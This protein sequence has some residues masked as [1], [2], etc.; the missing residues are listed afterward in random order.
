MY[1]GSK[2]MVL[3]FFK[4]SHAQQCVQHWVLLGVMWQGN[5][6]KVLPMYLNNY[7]FQSQD[8]VLGNVMYFDLYHSSSTLRLVAKKATVKKP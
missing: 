2:G 3:E 5:C 6:I 1:M 7:V 4:S 8:W